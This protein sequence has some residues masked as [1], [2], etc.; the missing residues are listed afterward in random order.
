M[1][2]AFMPQLLLVLFAL[3][4]PALDYMVKDKRWLAFVALTPLLGY[5]FAL[6]S[7]TLGGYWQPPSVETGVPLIEVNLFSG[8]FALAFVAVGIIVALSSPEFIRNERNQG[9][10][11]SLILLAVTGMTVVALATDLIVLFVG[12]EIA[13]I[14]SFALSGFSKKERR[15]AE[16]AT[17]YFIVGGFSSAMTLFAISLF[18]GVSGTTE[19]AAMGPQME[20]MFSSVD[21]IRSAATLATVMLIA[22]LGFKIAAVPFHMWAP[23]VYEGA[24]TPISGLLA[25][26][27]KKMGVAAMFKIFLVGIVVTKT[28]WEVAIAVIAVVTMTVGNLIAISQ[29]NIKRMLAYS[30]IAQAGYILIVLPIGTE[31]AVAGGLFHVLT[32]AFMKSGAFMVVAALTVRGIG[33]SLDDFRGLGKRSPFLALAMMLFLL[34]LA[35]IPPLAGFASKFV[36]FSSAVDA[37]IDPGPSWLVWLAVAGVLNSALSLYYYA[38]VIKKMYMEKG[39]E[40]RVTVPTMTGAAIV[41]ALVMVIVLG[42]YFDAV[43]ELCR[44]AAGSLLQA[45]P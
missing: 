8:A 3:I 40:E 25:A 16:A 27:S 41:I 15:S 9:E 28:D 4:M 19:I 45:I 38:R 33:E 17:K 11:Y 32:H 1:L 44:E 5:A 18:Y 31:Y 26:A 24:P 14:A 35:G 22:G 12:L 10:Y 20:A 34:S 43:L 7:W 37:S 36:L 39:P 29:S 23:D 30:S 2:N 13:G 21:G 6:A 42:I